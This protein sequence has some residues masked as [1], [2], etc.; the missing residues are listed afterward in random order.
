MIVDHQLIPYPHLLGGAH[1]YQLQ[2]V[3][4]TG[5]IRDR[6]GQGNR[7]RQTAGRT[8]PV[9]AASRRQSK[10]PSGF[11]LT[12]RLQAPG[13]LLLATGVIEPKLF[14]YQCGQCASVKDSLALKQPANGLYTGGIRQYPL[15]LILRV[16]AARIHGT[17]LFVQSLFL[18]KGQG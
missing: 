4:Q 14:T 12:Q 2:S 8:A 16:H 7:L 10:M 13:P 1:H 17:S 9:A 15:D 3:N 6:C 11:Q 5:L 18:G